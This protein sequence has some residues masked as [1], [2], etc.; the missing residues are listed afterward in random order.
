M[1]A[2]LQKSSLGFSDDEGD[3]ADV[4]VGPGAAATGA[5]AAATAEPTGGESVTDTAAS[6]SDGAG[7]AP[8]PT[9]AGTGTL[10]PSIAVSDAFNTAGH[11]YAAWAAIQ[12]G[13]TDAALGFAVVAVAA[14]FGTLRF[15]VSETTFAGLNGRLADLAVRGCGCGPGA[16][17]SGCPFVAARLPP[18]PRQQRSPLFARSSTVARAVGVRTSWPP[19]RSHPVPC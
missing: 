10:Y 16:G 7:G 14:F 9:T 13:R 19:L 3:D 11:C 17:A 4:D 6:R 8:V 2:Q 1:R 15:G 5:A 18:P 12:H